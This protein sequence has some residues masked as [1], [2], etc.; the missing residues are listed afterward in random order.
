MAPCSARLAS[1]KSREKKGAHQYFFSY[2]KFY[3]ISAP[4]ADTLTLV[5]T[6]PV[7]CSVPSDFLWFCAL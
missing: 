3:H 6:A 2:R 1:W 4:L 5:N 7:A